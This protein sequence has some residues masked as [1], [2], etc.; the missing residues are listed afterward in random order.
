MV[1]VILETEELLLRM[2]MNL[3]YIL[4][5]RLTQSTPCN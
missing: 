5:L 4:S 3:S 1:E 2:L